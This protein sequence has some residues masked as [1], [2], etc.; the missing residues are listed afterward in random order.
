MTT[1]VKGIML[2]WYGFIFL[3]MASA[4]RVLSF[5]NTQNRFHISCEPVQS[6]SA[7]NDWVNALVRVS[8]TALVSASSDRCVYLHKN[9]SSQ[10]LGHHNDYAKALAVGASSSEVYSGGFDSQILLWDLVRLKSAGKSLY[11]IRAIIVNEAKN[12]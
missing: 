7:H 12:C 4:Y 2:R 3:R 11:M 6:W 9:G 1:Y 5:T 8:S 10:K